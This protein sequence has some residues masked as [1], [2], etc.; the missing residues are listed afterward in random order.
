[1]T[2]PIVAAGRPRGQQRGRVG[3]GRT[4]LAQLP[5]KVQDL[6]SQACC[7]RC[8]LGLSEFPGTQDAEVLEIEVKAYRRLIRRRRYR[9]LPGW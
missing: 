5:V 7:P 8:G 6:T 4:R 3:H 9:A 2:H 1:M